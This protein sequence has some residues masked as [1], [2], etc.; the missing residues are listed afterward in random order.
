MVYSG[1]GVYSGVVQWCVQWW[2]TLPMQ[3][4]VSQG[5]VSLASE[6]A[7]SLYVLQS[8][9]TAEYTN[10]QPSEAVVED[11]ELAENGVKYPGL[12]KVKQIKF[13]LPRNIEIFDQP[14]IFKLV[15]LS[16]CISQV[17][18]TRL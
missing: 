1:N 5:S 11:L 9:L 18:N 7:C 17:N 13:C 2:S 14:A 8:P 12:F 4:E 16:L 15:I 10:Q 3:S 6:S